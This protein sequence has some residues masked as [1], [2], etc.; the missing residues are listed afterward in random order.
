MHNPHKAGRAAVANLRFANYRAKLLLAERDPPTP[1][2]DRQRVRYALR[3]KVA[4]LRATPRFQEAY[5][6]ALGILAAEPT[7]VVSRLNR[8]SGPRAAGAALLVLCIEGRLKVHSYN[9]AGNPVYMLGDPEPEAE[10]RRPGRPISDLNARLLALDPGGAITTSLKPSALI[11]ARS[12][13]VKHHPERRYQ[14]SHDHLRRN[15]ITRV[16]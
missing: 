15:I 1:E 6:A 13:I 12:W 7:L 3:V 5:D 16:A 14:V 8:F 4:N 11:G 9:A 10:R 2:N